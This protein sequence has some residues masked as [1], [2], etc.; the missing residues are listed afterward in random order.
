MPKKISQLT[1]LAGS[2]ADTD[3][4]EIAEDAGAGN[5]DSRKITVAQLKGAI[6]SNPSTIDMVTGTNVTG[7]LTNTISASILI[8]ANTITTTSVIELVSR[9]IRVS[10]TNSTST[11]QLYHNTSNSLSGA[12]LLAVFNPVT[13][14]NYFGQGIRSLFV[15]TAANQLTI[16]NAGVTLGS[17]YQNIGANSVIT[18]DETVANYLILAIQLSNIADTLKIQFAKAVLYV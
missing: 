15:D 9:S 8:P 10:G 18:F 13:N 11:H 7:T 2:L 6:V 1:A 3:L 5:Y 16:M 12:T 4:L 17:D 14:T